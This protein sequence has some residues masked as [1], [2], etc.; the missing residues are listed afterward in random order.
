MTKFIKVNGILYY[1]GNDSPEK[2]VAKACDELVKTKGKAKILIIDEEDTADTIKWALL[3][4]DTDIV[5]N[6]LYKAPAGFDVILKPDKQFYDDLD[7]NLEY[8]KIIV[9]RIK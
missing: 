5:E 8:D 6:K 3:K 1:K 9:V 4:K 2:A 7:I